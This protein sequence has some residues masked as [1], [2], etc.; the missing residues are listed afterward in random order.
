MNPLHW[1]MKKEVQFSSESCFSIDFQIRV[2]WSFWDYVLTNSNYV[3]SIGEKESE[4]GHLY[5][6]SVHKKKGLFYKDSLAVCAT[7]AR[8]GTLYY[9]IGFPKHW[10]A[11]TNPR[12]IVAK[13]SLLEYIAS[14]NHRW[15][16]WFLLVHV[17]NLRVSILPH[18]GRIKIPNPF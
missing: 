17:Q 8:T 6:K 11:F 13:S 10:K 14:W 12:N 4:T 16:G 15:T 2:C 9:F 7:R 1:T 3:S 18:N 5:S